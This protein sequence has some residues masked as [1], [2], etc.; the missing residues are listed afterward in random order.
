MVIRTLAVLLLLS[1]VGPANAADF[2]ASG[3]PTVPCAV[4]PHVTQANIHR[5]ICVPGWAAK[6]RPPTSVTN[7]IKRRLFRELRPPG[8]IAGYEL[9]H[10]ICI[11]CGG[12]LVDEVNLWLQRYDGPCNAYHKDDLERVVHHLIC[13]RQ[14]PIPL[15]EGQRLLSDD[16]IGAYARLVDPKGCR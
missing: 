16:W 10:C 14:H 15:V 11:A 2:D 1:T 3:L 6:Q 7:A 12:A 8:L 13:A 9:D 4:N 5:T